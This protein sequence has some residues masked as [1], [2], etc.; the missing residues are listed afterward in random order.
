MTVHAWDDSLKI[1]RNGFNLE[2]F[3]LH[4]LNAGWQ[5]S[6]L[7]ADNRFNKRIR[8]RLNLTFR[9]NPRVNVDN[10]QVLC[11]EEGRSYPKNAKEKKEA[12]D[13]NDMRYRH[14]IWQASF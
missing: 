1:T 14:P 10:K 11:L 7:T 5:W 13:T 8:Y 12:H 3:A 2:C 6:L 9:H 4:L